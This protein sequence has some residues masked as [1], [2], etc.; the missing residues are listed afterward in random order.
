M[1][2]CLPSARGKAEVDVRAVTPERGR[3]GE[4]LIVVEFG[5]HH[6]LDE[7]FVVKDDDPV[8]HIPTV[9]EVMGDGEQSALV[10]AKLV[11]VID[12]QRA[13]DRINGVAWLVEHDDMRVEQHAG[14]DADPFA[15][16]GREFRHL[17]VEMPLQFEGTDER[18]IL[19]PFRVD[20]MAAVRDSLAGPEQ[21]LPEADVVTHGHRADEI[22]VL[23]HLEHVAHRR[24][25][26][27]IDH[28]LPFTGAQQ[29]DDESEQR[30]LADAVVSEDRQRLALR[31]GEVDVLQHGLSLLVAEGDVFDGDDGMFAVVG[32]V[33]VVDVVGGHIVFPCRRFGCVRIR[34]VRMSQLDIG[35]DKISREYSG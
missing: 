19:Q 12:E 24:H 26:T 9:F 14:D 31:H 13:G 28:A 10:G 23:G 8:G 6:I 11:D 25:P 35:V 2:S 32:A 16:T 21:Q 22:A 17:L 15:Q 3:L 4:R 27:P 33:G 30:G 20:G 7:V 34:H 1:I 5:E 29:S 18:L